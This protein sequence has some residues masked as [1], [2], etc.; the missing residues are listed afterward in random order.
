MI[1]N[2]NHLQDVDSLHFGCEDTESRD[3]DWSRGYGEDWTAYAGTHLDC[4]NRVECEACDGGLVDQHDDSP[5]IACDVCE[6]SGEVECSHD[7]PAL[8]RSGLIECPECGNEEESDADAPMMSYYYP[9]PDHKTFDADDA[10]KLADLPLCLVNFSDGN[11][12]GDEADDRP[13]WA[14]ALT[15]GGMDLSWEI[16]EAH[17]RLGLLPPLFTCALPKYAGKN[18]Q[19]PVAAWV[20]AGC[21]RSAEAVRDRGQNMM[22]RLDEMTA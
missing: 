16:A 10:L 17:M 5:P 11:W 4:V 22:D 18:L 9:L 19:D 12:R 21:R 8:V 1:T 13:D 14:L 2:T 6:G 3:C 15:G 20:I 7:G